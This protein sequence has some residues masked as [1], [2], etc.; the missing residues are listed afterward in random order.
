MPQ[1]VDLYDYLRFKKSIPH[2]SNYPV[3]TNVQASASGLI[4]W[5]TDVASTSQVYYGVV[6]YLG[7]VTPYDSALVTSH[8]V[9][10]SSLTLNTRYYFKVLS[11]RS[12]ALSI[13]D[14]YSFV[15]TN[16]FGTY[17]V[18]NLTTDTSFDADDTSL[19]E[20]ANV[21]GSL[22]TLFQTG[23][24]VTSTFSATNVTT[25][26]SF[27]ANDMSLDTLADVI[28]TLIADLSAT[29]I[30]ANAYTPSN[31]TTTTLIDATNTSLDEISDVL[32]SL[33]ATLQGIGA[34]Q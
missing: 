19:D 18:S 31:V 8:S 2:S 29:G 34:I 11:F 10:L 5:T 14:L 22:I 26:R 9:Q 13:S 15:F 12:D 24:T 25:T 16:V 23:T 4:T 28:G 17:T 30:T 33:L 7:F 6:P 1:K 3:I 27:D 20:M 21:L 32:G